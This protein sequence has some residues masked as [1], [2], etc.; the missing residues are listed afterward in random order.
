[1]CGIIGLWSLKRALLNGVIDP[2]VRSLKHRGPDTSGVWYS[3]DK[4][5]ALGHTRL[6]IIDLSDN[7]N[8]PFISSS[9]KSIMAFNGEVY[10]YQELKAGLSGIPFKSTSDTEVL[11]EFLERNGPEGLTELNGMFSIAIYNQEKKEL[12]LARDRMGIKPLYVFQSEDLF[13]FASEIKSFLQHPE[14]KSR[15]NINPEAIYDFLHLGYI[16]EPLT[17]YKEISKFP[18]GHFALKNKNSDLKFTRYWNPGTEFR[19]PIFAVT[20]NPTEELHTLILD[21]VEKR[22]VTDVPLGTFLSGGTDSSLISCAAASIMNERLKTFTIGFKEEKYDES[23]DAKKVAGILKSDHTEFILEQGEATELIREIIPTYDQPFGDSSAIPMMLISSLAREKVKVILTGDGGDELFMGYGAYSW[24]D[25]MGNPFINPLLRFSRPFLKNQ[26]S[27]SYK[28]AARIISDTKG[29]F[30]SHLFS[31]EQYLFSQKELDAL[32]QQDGL[33]FSYKDPQGSDR[34]P[35]EKQAYF[36]LNYYLPDDLLEKVDRASMKYSLECRVPLL[37][38]RIVEFAQ[39]LP[40]SQKKKGIKRKI[41]L[42]RILE[43][44]LPKELIYKK[45]WGF[46]IPLSSWLKNN[47]DSFFSEILHPDSIRN[48]K[49]LNP[50]LTLHLLDQFRKGEESLYNKVWHIIV[51]LWWSEKNNISL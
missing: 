15:L 27:E 2:M 51:L 36:D 11:A 9:G 44:Y 32:I 40:L 21:S 3:D 42:K 33:Y 45:K 7:A 25:R 31:Q 19:K 43:Q 41:I 47:M 48:Q 46:S 24:A 5:L 10:N 1:M 18:K 29:N 14:I 30:R 4:D 28:K 35:S 37:D 38:H 20:S 26:K 17:I 6:S 49:T 34:A 50:D 8:Q 23:A 16:P 39:R 22:L 13:A 12:F